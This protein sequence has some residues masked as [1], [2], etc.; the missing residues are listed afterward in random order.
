MVIIEGGHVAPEIGSTN[1]ALST[2]HVSDAFNNSKLYA[3]VGKSRGKSNFTQ[4]GETVDYINRGR[5][6]DHC[7]GSRA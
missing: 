2:N 4:L 5:W 1:V 6:V 3:A 7:A